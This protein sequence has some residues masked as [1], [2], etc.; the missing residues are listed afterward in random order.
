MAIHDSRIIEY[1]SEFPSV[2]RDHGRRERYQV[3]AAQS[4][5]VSQT[6]AADFGR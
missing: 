5:V 4:A 2:S 3:L 6:V 1:R